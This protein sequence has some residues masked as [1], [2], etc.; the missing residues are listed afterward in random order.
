[1]LKLR[2]KHEYEQEIAQLKADL[3]NI[4]DF[5]E[6]ENAQLRNSRKNYKRKYLKLKG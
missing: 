5:Y 1:M 4:K 6:K 2:E 3:I